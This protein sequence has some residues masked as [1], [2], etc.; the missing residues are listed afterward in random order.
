MKS[1]RPCLITAVA[2][3]GWAAASPAA[4]TDEETALRHTRVERAVAVPAEFRNHML[5]VNV[6]VNG[7]GPFRVFVDTGC[8]VALFSPELAAAVKARPA[9]GD[10]TTAAVNAFG[11][12]LAVRRA[13]FD[14][15]QLGGVR[16]EGVIAGVLPMT[17][18]TQADGL[19]VDGVL[20]FS[21][22]SDVVVGLDYPGRRLLLGPGWPE[23]LPPLRA[24]MAMQEHAEVPFIAA[25][26]QNQSFE[27]EIDSGSNGSLHLPNE[28]AAALSWKAEPRPG[29]LIEAVDEEA[30]DHLGRLNGAL[31]LG[32]LVLPEPVA[33]VGSP[34][35]SIGYDVWG[36]FCI[37]F[38]QRAGKVRFYSAESGP[39]ASPSERSVGLSIKLDPAG[40]RIAGVVPGSPAEADRL[41]AGDLITRIEGAPAVDWSRDQLHDWVETH[42]A[43]RLGVVSSGSSRDLNLRVWLLVP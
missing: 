5:F 25:E 10:E 24:E 15:I 42:D 18:L 43:M 9:P 17:G 28:L 29:L 11:N 23:N 31:T 13:L 26:L 32:G 35:P 41:V 3:A 14:S 2:I 34:A 33:S 39:I 4:E 20:G 36:R 12:P 16:F 37:V 7:Q 30:R 38:D 8:S 6:M 21:L 19:R 27:I 40:W 1:F 22:F